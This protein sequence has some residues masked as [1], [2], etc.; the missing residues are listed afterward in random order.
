[1]SGEEE[2]GVIRISISLPP[3][4]LEQLDEFIKNVGYASRSKVIQDAIRRF[5]TEHEVMWNE[6]EEAVG[7]IAIVYRHDIRKLEE[8]ITDIQHEYTQT[9]TSTIHIHLTR[10]R[11]FEIIALKGK[12]KHMR[13]LLNSLEGKRGVEHAKLLIVSKI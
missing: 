7:L 6:E 11:C 5:I 2:K 12:V 4:L 9:I 3:K 10:E 8:E 13:E 1:M